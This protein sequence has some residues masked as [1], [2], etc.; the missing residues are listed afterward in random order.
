MTGKRRYNEDMLEAAAEALGR[1]PGEI[2]AVNPL[3]ASSSDR[4]ARIAEALSERDRETLRDMAEAL[5]RRAAGDK[6]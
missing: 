2:L 4:I 5:E 1:T 6:K 3:E